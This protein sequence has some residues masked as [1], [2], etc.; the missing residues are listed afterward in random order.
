[1]ARLILYGGYAAGF[2]HAPDSPARTEFRAV[3]DLSRVSWA[4][5]NPA[6]RSVFTSQFIPGGSDEQLR[7]FNDLC[8]RS[9]TGPTAARLLEACSNIDVRPLLRQVSTPTLV[10]HARHDAVV[11]V[12]AGR[13]LVSCQA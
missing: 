4:K 11:P 12:T 6:F 5:D 10:L 3:V 13:R 7:W 1:M 9:T 2:A 8:R